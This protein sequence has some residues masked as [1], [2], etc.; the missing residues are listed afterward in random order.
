MAP[1]N[2]QIVHLILQMQPDVDVFKKRLKDNQ[3]QEIWKKS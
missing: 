1:E 2:V 3:A